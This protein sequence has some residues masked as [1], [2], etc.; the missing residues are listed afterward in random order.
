[1]GLHIELESNRRLHVSVFGDFDFELSR[2]VLLQVKAHCRNGVTDVLIVLKGVTRISSA[3]IGTL[4]LLA[5]MAGSRVS[6]RSECCTEQVY[7]LFAPDLLGRYF[8]N[9]N[10]D[11]HEKKQH[12]NLP[13]AKVGGF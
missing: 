1:M 7:A 13:T 3:A 12:L 6:L 8:P 5:E 4:A 9:D 2:D 11:G 10:Y